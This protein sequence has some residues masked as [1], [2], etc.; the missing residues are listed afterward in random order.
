MQTFRAFLIRNRALVALLAAAM[1]CFKAL[2]PAGT[3][4][5]VQNHVLT[6]AICADASSGKIVKQIVIP[7]N[8]KHDQQSKA[9]GACP[10]SALG[11]GAVAPTDPLQLVLA[12]AFILA[13]GF[14]PLTA[15]APERRERLR[16]PLRGPPILA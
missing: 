8:G 6:V 12:L 5:T 4:L 3:M 9:D 7:I 13:L 10:W 14:L 1:L 15:R 11:M 2:L 16:P